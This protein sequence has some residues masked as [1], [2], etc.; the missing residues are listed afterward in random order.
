VEHSVAYASGSF[1]FSRREALAAAVLAVLA[2]AAYV[3]IWFGD[4][5]FLNADDNEYVTDNPHMQAGLTGPSLWWALTAYHSNNWHPLTWM[6]LQLDCQLYGL[7]PYGFHAT[8]VLLHAANT[9]LL[10]LALRSLTGAVCQS[11]VVAAFFAVHPLH[12][13]SVAWVS[14]RK[15]VLSTLFWMLTLWAYSAYAARPGWGRYLLTLTL[16]GLGLTAKPML[17]TLPCVLLLL[18]YWPLR[19]LRAY[20][21]TAPAR[22]VPSLAGAAGWWGLVLEKLPFF[23]LAAGCSLLTLGAQQDI[24]QSLDSLPLPYRLA[25]TPL[26]YL[27]YIG[28]MFWP[29]PLAVYYPHRGPD[30]SFGLP[31][32]AAGLLLGLTALAFWQARRRPYLAVGW[33]WYLGTLVPVIGLVQ[34]ARQS[35]ADRYTYVPLIGLF[36]LLAWG[37]YDLLGRRRLAWAATAIVAGLAAACL[38]LTWRQ[39]PFWRDSTTLWQHALAVSPS[40]VAHQ[41]MAKVLEKEGRIDEARREYA[42]AIRYDPCPLAYNNVGIFLARHGWI[43]D[44]L[45]HFAQSLELYPDQVPAHYNIG[46]IRLDQGKL[47]EARRHLAEVLRLNPS[48]ADGH[49]YLG[50]VLERQGKFREA[51]GELMRA[52]RGKRGSANARYHLGVVLEGQGRSNDAGE[53]FVSA[54]WSDPNHVEAHTSLGA[55][56]ARMGQLAAGREHLRAALKRDPQNGRAHFNLAL[57]LAL[58]GQRAEACRQFADAV[59]AAP[60]DAE[61]R[62]YLEAAR[63]Q[64]RREQFR[65]MPQGIPSR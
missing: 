43:D 15:D 20:R 38:V 57:A 2:L 1:G 11:A 31:A 25:N 40:G 17:V 61:A 16:F 50:L 41:N 63:P 65:V 42:E 5:Q 64:P 12:V 52:L 53:W 45:A 62:R 46:R 60:D 4:Y 47:D 8:N 18:D 6:S 30:R 10:F 54:L 32:A 21:P 27:A 13:E 36:L 34:V 28:M 19:R 22:V 26:A 59:A 37:T 49:Y 56:V 35:H 24:M 44:A 48:Y 3:P 29:M 14:E 55:L 7:N 51:E 9:V 23:A 58:D 33:L 39:L